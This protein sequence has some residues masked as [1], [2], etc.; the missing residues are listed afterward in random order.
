[1]ILG[2]ICLKELMLI[3][4]KSY[5]GALVAVIITFLK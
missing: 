4:P 2:F 1:M 5:E 3:K